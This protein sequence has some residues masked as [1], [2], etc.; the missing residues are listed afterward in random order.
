ME[1]CSRLSE[2][3]KTQVIQMIQ[4]I[5]SQHLTDFT[6]EDLLIEELAQ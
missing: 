1:T 6:E 3:Q 2:I 5:P 4:Q